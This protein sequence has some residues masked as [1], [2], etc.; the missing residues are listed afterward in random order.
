MPALKL[1]YVWLIFDDPRPRLRLPLREGK[2]NRL[3]WTSI[4]MPNVNTPN[5]MALQNQSKTAE[6]A[7]DWAGQSPR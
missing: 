2:D 4:A 7:P 5:S 1:I 6:I 3:G